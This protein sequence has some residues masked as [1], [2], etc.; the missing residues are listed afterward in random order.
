M[1]SGSRG[2]WAVVVLASISCKSSGSSSADE[3]PM[4]PPAER[5][6]PA[7]TSAWDAPMPAA[8]PIAAPVART[9]VVRKGD[10]LF[11]LARHYYGDQSQWRRIWDANKAALPDPNRIKVGQSLSIPD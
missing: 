10:T 4:E 11:V 3:I 6:A 7:A 8:A 5:S 1:R 2:A 9:H